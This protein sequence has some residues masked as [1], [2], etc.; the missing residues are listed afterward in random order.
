MRRTCSRVGIAFDLKTVWLR[1]DS[2]HVPH[3][4]F[5]SL[6]LF[7]FFGSQSQRSSFSLYYHNMSKTCMKMIRINK[8]FTPLEEMYEVSS[9]QQ[10]ISLRY[11]HLKRQLFPSIAKYPNNTAHEVPKRTAALKTKS[12]YFSNFSTFI[13]SRVSIFPKI[14]RKTPKFHLMNHFYGA[15]PQF[16]LQDCN[17]S[18][19]RENEG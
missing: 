3:L 11:H 12:I 8:V 13:M 2:G 18:R 10:F 6:V 5:L 19:C 9:K 17:C 1:F 7:S 16:K 15:G 14:T 4:F